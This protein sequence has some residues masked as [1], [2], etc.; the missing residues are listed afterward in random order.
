M[1]S[2]DLAIA[3]APSAHRPPLARHL[4]CPVARSDPCALRRP[5]RHMASCPA[6]GPPSSR[7]RVAPR[8]SQLH[9]ATPIAAPGCQLPSPPGHSG[10]PSASTPS[11][12]SHWKQTD[13]WD[14]LLPQGAAPDQHTGPLRGC[15][16]VTEA[17]GP[18]RTRSSPQ[19]RGGRCREEGGREKGHSC[20]L[21]GHGELGRP[22]NTRCPR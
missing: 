17:S 2:C 12:S 8:P 3:P 7:S 1:G 19:T 15:P 21:W 9:R 20:G 16:L 6:P 11:G 13:G 14:T 22:A 4:F 18:G 5:S 10:T